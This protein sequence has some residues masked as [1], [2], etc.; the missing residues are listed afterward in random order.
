[1]PHELVHDSYAFMLCEP[2]HLHTYEHAS[3]A[4]RMT[5]ELTREALIDS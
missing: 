4:K 5:H 1:M 3:V 2:M